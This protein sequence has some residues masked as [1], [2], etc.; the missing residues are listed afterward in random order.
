[1]LKVGD[2]IPSGKFPVFT[3]TEFKEVDIAELTKGKKAVLFAIPGPFTPTCN[4]HTQSFH[5]HVKSLKEK[6]VEVVVC[7]SKADP[8]VMKTYGEQNNLEDDVI[9]LADWNGDYIKK[10]G[11][12]IDLSVAFM[13][14]RSLRFDAI[15]KDGI[16]SHIFI[17]ENP[18][19][20]DQTDAANLLKH[21]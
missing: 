6:G 14:P 12:E 9:M 13:G 11:A 18:I 3:G 8:F 21:L 5:D 19:N 7:L 15:M 20:C 16:I 2:K 1:M 10:I 4:A 17:D